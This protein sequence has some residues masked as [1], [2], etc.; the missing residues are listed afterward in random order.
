MTAS[1]FYSYSHKDE[2]LRVKLEAHLASLKR[3][4][5]ISE[6]H[7]RKII[8][9]TD[10]DCEIDEHLETADVILLLI[11]SDFIASNYCFEKEAT[12]AMERHESGEA[13]VV[14]VIL[15]PCSWQ[16]L[17]FGKLQA[18][19]SDGKPVT[20]H[21]G[22]DKAFASVVDGIRAVVKSRQ[23]AASSERNREAKRGGSR[24]GSSQQGLPLTSIPDVAEVAQCLELRF[25]FKWARGTFALKE[26]AAVVYWPVRLRRPMAI[27]AVQAFAASAL[28]KKGAQVVLWLDDLG[29]A[30]F[31]ANEFTDRIRHWVGRVGGNADDLAVR[32]F[33]DA[34]KKSEN[35]EHI[36][37][38]V[39][40]WLA[41]QHT[42]EL[43]GV[44]SVSKLWPDSCE[45]PL[46]TL[47]RLGSRRPRRLLT[48]PVVWTCLLLLN[49]EYPDNPV[50]TLG[51]FDE[52]PLWRVWSLC[53]PVRHGR[54]GHLYNPI[55]GKR[56]AAEQPKTWYMG[57]DPLSWNSLSDIKSDLRAQTQ[58]GAAAAPANQLSLPHWAF[59]CCS[60]LPSFVAGDGDGYGEE[61]VSAETPELHPEE[62]RDRDMESESGVERLALAISRWYL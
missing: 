1:L 53:A 45:D 5:L 23:S 38:Y 35:A 46:E 43:K 28:Q 11:S 21:R 2:D 20:S 49:Q 60:L 29:N 40:Q 42:P 9:G 36:W 61:Q 19:P 48:P 17:P 14:P 7:D 56:S 41:G 54:V 52:E 59:R 26:T 16:K 8:A 57:D 55:L 62:F 12:R 58:I 33:S 32:L 51:G 15:R 3:E 18:L 22:K 27:H 47:E 30:Q 6:W 25:G 34:I 44:L 4:G 50:I 31:P 37:P 13:T 39:Q 24:N 10:S